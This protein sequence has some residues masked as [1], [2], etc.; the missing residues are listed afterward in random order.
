MSARIRHH[1]RSNVI[2]YLA[3]FVA[4]GGTAYATHPGGANTISSGDIIDG[5][6][7]NPDIGANAVGTGKIID[8]TIRSA[9][10]G[11][12]AVN[13]AE[14][15]SGA[16]RTA[17]IQNG[18]VLSADVANNSLTGADVADTDSL[19]S[20]EIGGLGGG[21]VTDGSITDADTSGLVPYGHVLWAVVNSDGSL[22]RASNGTTTSVLE[23]AGSGDYEVDFGNGNVVDPCASIAQ[24]SGSN[25]GFDELPG[26][27]ASAQGEPSGTGIDVRTFDNAGA[28]ADRAFTVH[29]LCPELTDGGGG[30]AKSADR[31]RR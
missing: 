18:Q 26:Q 11:T 7:M 31:G 6:V 24:I 14:I 13:S 1:I 20:P 27:A 10:I 28:A 15:T 8:D 25:I 23:D 2:G 30:T 3:L 12:D 21:D 22:S 19:G 16:V 29:V 9:D 5:Q 4:L 17:E